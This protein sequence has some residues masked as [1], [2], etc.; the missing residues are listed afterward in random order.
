MH[1]EG[2]H[3]TIVKL[4]FREGRIV[5]S[6]TFPMQNVIGTNEEVWETFL[7][8]H[9]TNDAT[10][11]KTLLVPI[12]LPT[13]TEILETKILN[14]KRGTKKKLLDLAKKN[15]KVLFAQES[16]DQKRARPNPPPTRRNTPPHQMS[17]AHRMFRHLKHLR[18][19]PSR[20]DGHFYR[21]PLQQKRATHLQ[22]QRICWR[23]LCRDARSA[24]PQILKRKRK[25]R[26]PR[27]HHRRWWQRAAKHP[28]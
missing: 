16:M 1:R 17:A 7:L 10:L 20:L 15:A 18:L 9:Y 3:L 22:N 8:G 5:G 4:I 21:W 24:H 13:L 26:S 28:Y 12:K 6:N 27:S 23:R 2:D 14:P 25:R 19:R 11:P